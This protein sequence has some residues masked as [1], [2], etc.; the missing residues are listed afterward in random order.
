MKVQRTDFYVGI[1]VL[2]AAAAVVA[3]LVTTSGW[4]RRTFDLYILADNTA[5]ISIDTKIF[6]QGLEVGRV[7]F[8][9]PRPSSRQGELEFVIHA[10]MTA[11]FADGTPLQLVRG[12]TAEVETS[13]LGASTLQLAVRDTIPGRLE[14]GDT[15]PMIRTS[16]ALEAF[17]ALA[18]DLK[19]S[20]QGALAATT[21]ALRSVQRLSDSLAVTSSTARN[22]L[23]GM[24]PGIEKVLVE[25][26]ANLERT[27]RL[28]DSVDVRSGVT[29]GQVDST[30]MQSR[31]LM[32]SVDSLTR[33]VTAM[34]GENRPEIRAIIVNS[35][36]LSE[37]LLFVMEEMSKR[38]TRALSGVELPESLTAAGRARRAAEDSILRVLQRDSTEQR[39]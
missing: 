12:V 13:I 5:G 30:L 27:R 23:L 18:R 36:L 16:P 33:L 7:A 9:A 15:I 8:I 35:R 37:Q 22:F 26:A 11:Q 4:G 17:G 1:F 3:A 6:M 28:L 34:G 25:V 29:M 20:I 2:T 39:P 38:P 31:R 32:A 19:G 14:P 24:Q 10:E 21:D